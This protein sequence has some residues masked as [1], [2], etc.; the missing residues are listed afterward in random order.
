MNTKQPLRWGILGTGWIADRFVDDL[1]RLEGHRAALV[2]SR[3]L[4]KAQEFATRHGMAR[5]VGSYEALA[6]DPEVDV[7]YVASPHPHHHAHA[8]LALEAGKAVLLEKP[9]TMDAREAADLVALARNQ[10]LFLMEAMWTRFLPHTAALRRVL[11]SGV[12]GEVVQV[13]ADHGQWFPRDPHHRI[14]APELGGG[15]L[16]DLGIYPVSFAWFVLGAPERITAVSTPAF[17]GIDGTTSMVLQYP[18]GAHAVLTTTSLARTPNRA[19]IAGTEARIEIDPWF[20]TPTSFTVIRTDGTVLERFHV[21]YEGHGLREQAAE[22]GRCLAS[23]LTES[24]LLPLDE[25]VA[26]L[27]TLDEVRRQIGLTY[28]PVSR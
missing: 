28:P 27:G 20:F 8:R 2:G 17:T 13:Q 4:A 18:T 19:L 16:L 24:P 7:V 11:G 15:A 22:V 23:G 26:I 6:N 9:F 25:S 3:T 14:F 10:G 12:L 1:K 21:P 5:A